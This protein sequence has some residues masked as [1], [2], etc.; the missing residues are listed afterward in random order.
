MFFMRFA[1]LCPLVA[2]AVSA[3]PNPGPVAETERRDPKFNYEPDLAGRT[4][5][6]NV[7]DWPRRRS[8]AGEYVST[9]F[10]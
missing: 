10:H 2:L 7:L 4:S 1:L 9:D 3:M 8:S 6:S 5:D